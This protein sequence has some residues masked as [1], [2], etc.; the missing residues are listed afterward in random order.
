MVTTKEIDKLSS[1]EIVERLFYDPRTTW[2]R[3]LRDYAMRFKKY[4]YGDARSVEAFSDMV[5]EFYKEIL[6]LSLLLGR[7]GEKEGE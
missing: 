7:K 1:S 2:E 5:G 3:K 4:A 6:K